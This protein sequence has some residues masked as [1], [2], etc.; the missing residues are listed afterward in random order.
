MDSIITYILLGI[1][2]MTSWQ[3]FDK[4]DMRLKMLFSPRDVRK[5]GE[6]YRFISAGLIHAD[7]FHL[8]FNMLALYSFGQIVEAYYDVLFGMWGK[9]L[10]LLLYFGAMITGDIAAYFRYQ[11]RPYFSLGASGAVSGVVFAFIL[12]QPWAQIMVFFIPMPAVVAGAL[13]VA[14]SYYAAQRGSAD[15]IAHDAH[16][17][18]GLFGLCFTILLS[19]S[20]LTQFINQIMP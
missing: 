16:L 5:R 9:L 10:Y 17:L 3:A 13:Y 20:L 8:G 19:P 12:F 14:Y 6:Y 2:V 7:W 18:G 4:P 15:G 1:T 11:D